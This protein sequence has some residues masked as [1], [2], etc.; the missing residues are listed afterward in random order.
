L[1]PGCVRQPAAEPG[2]AADET[3][4][5]R[6]ALPFGFAQPVALRHAD[7]QSVAEP[8]LHGCAATASTGSDV[9][10]AVSETIP[11]AEPVADSDPDAHP[12][13]HADP[14]RINVTL[15]R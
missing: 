10:A 5:G 2:G 9:A 1:V 12:D 3:S 8:A 7:A 11:E 6:R 13:P 15:I 14:E 4:P